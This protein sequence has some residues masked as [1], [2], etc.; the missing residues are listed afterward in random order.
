VTGAAPEPLTEIRQRLEAEQQE[1]G[2]EDADVDLISDVPLELAKSLCGFKH[3]DE[4]P[5]GLRLTVLE[6]SRPAR[7]DGDGKPG[8]LARLFGRA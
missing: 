8:F 1:E 2:G 3:D 4:W 7:S 6:R 5:E